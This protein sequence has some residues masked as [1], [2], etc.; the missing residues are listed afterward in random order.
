[1]NKI[2]YLG[3]LKGRDHL[4]DLSVDWNIILK[5]ILENKCGKVWTGFSWFRIGTNGGLL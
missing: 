3:N 2:F 1:M 5:W 4:E